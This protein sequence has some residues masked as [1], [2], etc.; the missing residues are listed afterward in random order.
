MDVPVTPAEDVASMPVEEPESASLATAA[1]GNPR[2]RRSLENEGEPRKKGRS[3]F[4]QA[5]GTL[6]KARRENVVT[7][8]V[9]T[10]LF[11]WW[12][13]WIGADAGTIDF[14]R[15]RGWRLTIGSWEKSQKSKLLQGN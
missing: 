2:K 15:R 8:A 13:V 1:A 14:R 4:G 11:S 7:E 5:F 10:T 3:I 6:K 9:S 12:L